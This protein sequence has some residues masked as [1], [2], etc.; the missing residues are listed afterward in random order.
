[1]KIKTIIAEDEPIARELLRGYLEKYCPVIEVIAE[2]AD[3]KTAIDMIIEHKPKLVFLD[4]EMPFGNAFDILHATSEIHYEVIFATA[5]SEYAIKAL[6]ENA[7]YYLLKPFDIEQ[8]ILAVEK[9]RQKI[10]QNISHTNFE[11]ISKSLKELRSKKQIIL[12][13]M[14]GFDVAKAPEILY[15]RANGNFT[16]VHLTSGKDIMVCKVLR[17][18]DELLDDRFMRVHRSYIVNLH[19]I[20]SY[21]KASGGV[22]ILN[23]GEE[24]EVSS[25]YRQQLLDK[26]G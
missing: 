19:A 6:N 4:V 16:D 9:I 25:S 13:T 11:A 21:H 18:F 2:A 15:L 7:A 20:K 14:Q 8:I 24:I 23:N 26:L 5:Y 10:E 22:L 17:Y 3:A 1:M 12:P